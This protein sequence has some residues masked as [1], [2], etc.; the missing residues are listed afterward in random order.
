[1]STGAMPV[2]NTG[3]RIKLRINNQLIAFAR[4][5]NMNISVDQ[6]PVPVMGDYAYASIEPTFYN[7]V[8]GTF[9][10]MKLASATAVDANKAAAQALGLN[11]PINLSATTV[12]SVDGAGNEIQTGKVQNS[13]VSPASETGGSNS[14]LAIQALHRHLNPRQVLL[15]RLFNFDLYIRVLDTT[16]PD[17]QALLQANPSPE[18]L[19]AA[20]RENSFETTKPYL[21]VKNVRIVGRNT[22]VSLIR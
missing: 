6:Q 9:Q 15:S 14:P 21:S 11:N 18:A 3:A 19:A 16:N 17:V 2:F 4:G 7:V 8:T 13:A 5:L 1:M 12:T 22:N 20:F 10:I